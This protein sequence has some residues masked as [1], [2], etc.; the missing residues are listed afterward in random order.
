MRGIAVDTAYPLVDFNGDLVNFFGSNPSG[1]PLTVIINCLVNSLYMR[2]V[3]HVLNPAHK[4]YSFRSHVSLMTYGDDNIMSVSEKA[5]WYN[6][7]TIAKVFADMDI[8]YTMPDK[9]SESV[10]YID[11]KAATFL[12]RSWRFDEDVGAYMAVLD[13][14]SIEKM[15]L[16]WVRSKAV[17]EEEQAVSVLSSALREY[18]YYG[19]KVFHSRRQRFK[20]VI[21]E[22]QLEPWVEDWV[23]PTWDELFTLFWD[24]ST[25]LGVLPDHC[26]PA[27]PITSGD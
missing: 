22:L 19:K 6:H 20:E 14:E 23:L 17:C 11:I 21:A 4:A 27:F 12:K 10:P 26:N 3:Y 5:P 16:T 18:F 24:T 13:H 7:T 9:E 1:H 8:E 15:L 25:R 2:Y